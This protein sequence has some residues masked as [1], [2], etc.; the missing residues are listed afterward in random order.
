VVSHGGVLGSIE[1]ALGSLSDEGY[2]HLTGR[3]FTLSA[4]ATDEK[5]T[6]AP[7]NFRLQV[8]Q[9]QTR[10]DA[11]RELFA[12]GEIV[13]PSALRSEVRRATNTK[14]YSEA[15]E[16]I[17]LAL[18]HN[19]AQ[20]WMYEALGLAMQL[21]HAPPEEIERA[22]MSALDFTSGPDHMLFLATYMARIGMDHR[23]LKLYQQVAKLEPLRPEPYAF[24]LSAAKRLNDLEGYV[25]RTFR[26]V[27]ESKN[28]GFMTRFDPRLPA[29]WSRL[30]FPLR[31]HDRQLTVD[32]THDAAT[33][34]VVEGDPLTI[35]VR[36]EEVALEPGKPVTVPSEDVDD[37]HPAAAE[38][39]A[40]LP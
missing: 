34:E 22:L 31:F 1:R 6:Q 15:T 28:L 20:P 10:M 9:G 21:E 11:W 37:Q 14:R 5:A 32:L 17:H 19:Q 13:P 35:N 25:E 33:F 16:L 27:A 12:A 24:G 23:A 3:W 38:Q 18:R 40:A 29:P 30:A 26:H 4:E 39:D 2:P 7:S 8:A 36:G